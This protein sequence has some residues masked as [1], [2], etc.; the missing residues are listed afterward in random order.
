ML[1][2]TCETMLMVS[3]PLLLHPRPPEASHLALCGVVLGHGGCAIRGWDARYNQMCS[4][5]VMETDATKV[6]ALRPP[7]SAILKGKGDE[8]GSQ[9]QWNVHLGGW[10]INSYS[11]E[12][13]ASWDFIHWL[14]NPWGVHQRAGAHTDTEAPEEI[15]WVDEKDWTAFLPLGMISFLNKL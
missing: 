8:G 2:I 10:L 13:A 6:T 1:I 5:H 12:L 14:T 3:F 9:N 7:W 15:N 4:L 11:G